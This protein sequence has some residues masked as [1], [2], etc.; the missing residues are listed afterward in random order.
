M[1]AYW[2]DRRWR[3]F[4]GATVKIWDLANYLSTKGYN[5]FLFLPRYDF[6]EVESKFTTIEVPFIDFPIIRKITFNIVLSLSIFREYLKWKPKFFYV[7]RGLSL[8]PLLFAKFA[9]IYLVYE[10]ND[11]P[12]RKNINPGS[13]HLINL[14]GSL[15]NSS[16]A[17]L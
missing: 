17:D 14:C 2:H 3:K 9:K 5:V 4:V 7:R 8:V 15:K 11:D 6:S 12:F 13:K 16:S 10:V 1:F